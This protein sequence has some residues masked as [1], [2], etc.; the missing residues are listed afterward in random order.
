M[1]QIAQKNNKNLVIL[2]IENRLNMCY[3]KYRKTRKGLTTMTRKVIAK[4]MIECWDYKTKAE[5]TNKI[6]FLKV[7][8][9][10]TDNAEKASDIQNAIWYSMDKMKRFA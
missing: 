6:K 9:Y 3:N 5:F 8:M 10:H 2:R 4:I 1:L 7:C